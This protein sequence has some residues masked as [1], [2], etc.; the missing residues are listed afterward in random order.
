MFFKGPRDV[1]SDRPIHE[2]QGNA[3]VVGCSHLHSF[4][5][6]SQVFHA[7]SSEFY[8]IDIDPQ[9][10]PDLVFDITKPLPV[11]L[12]NRFKLTLVEHLDNHAYNNLKW[13]SLSGEEGT[14]GFDN[15][16]EMTAADGFVLFVGC[17]RVKEFREQ[18]C[19]RDL[20]VIE[21]DKNGETVLICKNQKLNQKEIQQHLDI[22]PPALKSTI[23]QAILLKA[24]NPFKIKF[25]VV[26][27]PFFSEP[28]EQLQTI[29]ERLL[30]EIKKTD[31]QFRG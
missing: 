29:G 17:P 16:W 6:T 8:T 1:A 20:K 25:S 15:I 7:S 5:E 11:D 24:P 18:I 28:F 9:H 2:F 31:I 13:A 10:R 3:V 4:C 22:L 23:Y 19:L 26:D 14:V 30:A 21:L 27:L 12:K